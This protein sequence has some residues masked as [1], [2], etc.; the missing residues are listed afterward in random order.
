MHEH[1]HAGDFFM[2]NTSLMQNLANVDMYVNK[3]HWHHVFE[4]VT[5]ESSVPCRLFPEN[6]AHT[7]FF[8]TLSFS[9]QYR[10][11]RRGGLDI[12]GRGEVNRE[13]VLDPLP[14]TFQQLLMVVA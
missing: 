7:H 10:Q 12:F 2:C 5:S 8:I 14:P 1:K 3:I 11:I 4:K 13:A 6:Q 9:C